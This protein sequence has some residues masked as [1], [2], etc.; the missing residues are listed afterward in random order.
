MTTTEARNIP[1][2]DYLREAAASHGVEITSL[3]TWDAR[4]GTRGS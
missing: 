2:A 1:Y 4:H 3:H